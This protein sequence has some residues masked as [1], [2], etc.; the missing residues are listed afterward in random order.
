MI[1]AL[2]YGLILFLGLVVNTFLYA[3]FN[4]FNSFT[5]M[6]IRIAFSG[7]IYKKVFKFNMSGKESEAPG[8]IM[9]LITNDVAK[10]ENMF[11]QLPFLIVAPL[12]TIFFV[13]AFARLVHVHFLVG[14]S[15]MVLFIPIQYIIGKLINKF[16]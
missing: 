11:L 1:E 2:E 8:R 6:K 3:P 5:G 10:F 7:L 13:V 16:K 14:I 9:N 15:V 12:Q 4:L